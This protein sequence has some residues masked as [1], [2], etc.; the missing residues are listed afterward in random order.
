M[1][2]DAGPAAPR[3]GSARVAANRLARA[4]GTGTAGVAR[5]KYA[6]EGTDDDAVGFGFRRLV[7]GSEGAGDG[8]GGGMDSL[9]EGVVRGT[10]ELDIAGLTGETVEV[11]AGS[12]GLCEGPLPAA[13]IEPGP[14]LGDETRP[15]I[16]SD[17]LRFFSPTTVHQHHLFSSVQVQPYC[18]RHSLRG[19]SQTETQRHR[20]NVPSASA[21]F[22]PTDPFALTALVSSSSLLSRP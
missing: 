6:E 5:G 17:S 11:V 14:A 8:L 20:E 10:K 1:D 16:V 7:M 3:E 12:A 22:A 9:L 19:T 13:A 4:L 15:G 21:F 18:P 2:D